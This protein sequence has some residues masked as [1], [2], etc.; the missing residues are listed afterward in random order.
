[1][2]H[3]PETLCLANLEE[4][5]IRI[6]G[7]TFMM[8]GQSILHAAKLEHQ[9]TLD[10][11]YLCRFQVSQQLWGE[12]LEEE[13]PRVRFQGK[14]RPI[15]GISWN[16]ITEKFLPAL[17]MKSGINDYCL[18]TEAQWEYA[19][20]GG[21]ISRLIKSALPKYSGSDELNEVGWYRNNSLSETHT[22]GLKLP[23]LLGLYDMS[24]NVWEW[25]Q[26]R[27]EKGY[28]EADEIPVENGKKLKIDENRKVKRVIRGGS[29]YDRLGFS[30]VSRFLTEY[31]H[32]AKNDLGFRLCSSSLL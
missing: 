31:P 29:F 21:Q 26:D 1:M 12:I 5:M 24:G 22:C 15:E 10:S 17:R 8:G 6:P 25:C 14:A 23:N 2:L 16:I 18:P 11:F 13:I 28:Y 30:Q 19:A 7:G 3:L 32:H 27:L 4:N 9:I 20:R